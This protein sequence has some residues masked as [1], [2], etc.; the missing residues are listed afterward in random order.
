MVNF[1]GKADLT[2]DSHW[3]NSQ[4]EFG[5]MLLY[6]VSGTLVACDSGMNV[7]GASIAGVLT[8]MGGSTMN[9]LL[10]GVAPVF[11]MREP[12]WLVVC[13]GTAVVTFYL[14]PM[15]EASLA[16]L[17]FRTM[18]PDSKGRVSLE[19]FSAWLDRGS[20]R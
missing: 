8:G 14:W 7:V 3:I 1:I 12:F 4:I 20:T 2:K 6:V 16:G 10:M 18:D 13:T 19:G 9:E 17:E 5:G 15:L 11:W